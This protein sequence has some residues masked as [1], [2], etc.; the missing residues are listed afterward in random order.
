MTRSVLSRAARTQIE[1]IYAYSLA[2][3]GKARADQYLDGLL[4]RIASLEAGNVLSKPLPPEFEIDGFVV[5]FEK[6]YIYW[7]RMSRDRTGVVAVLH[8]SMLQTDRLRDAYILG[9]ER[10]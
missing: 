5:R 8:I 1:D 2:N 3:W 7:C 4:E 6:H 9:F 10:E